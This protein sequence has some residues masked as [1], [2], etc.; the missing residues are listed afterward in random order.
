M[1]GWA[2]FVSADRS[3]AERIA[4]LADPKEVW[5]GVEYK[6]VPPAD[7]VHLIRVLEGEQGQAASEGEFDTL[8][9]DDRAW[10]FVFPK[11]LTLLL[12]SLQ[13]MDLSRVARA[14]LVTAGRRDAPESATDFLDGLHEVASRAV[15]E[16]KWIMARQ[17]W[18]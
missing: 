9:Q 1:S 6:H 10:I 4:D 12:A 18:T 14:W 7:L 15:M 5:P 16:G 17:S 13:P 2:D 3:D 11:R 8:I